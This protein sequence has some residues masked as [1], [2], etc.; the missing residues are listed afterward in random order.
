MLNHKPHD[1]AL[2]DEFTLS[3]VSATGSA[4]VRTLKILFALPS[5]THPPIET[6]NSRPRYSVAAEIRGTC[7]GR[8]RPRANLD[9]GKSRCSHTARE[10][11]AVP[12][13]SARRVSPGSAKFRSRRRDAHKKGHR[14]PY[15]AA[16]RATLRVAE[17]ATQA[18]DGLLPGWRGT[19]LFRPGARATR[20]NIA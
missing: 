9:A 6:Y 2:V 5:C 10:T 16:N 3:I 13:I 17:E 8:D 20:E 7:R 15:S 1:S 4:C 11:T 19:Y 18:E 14:P 12:G